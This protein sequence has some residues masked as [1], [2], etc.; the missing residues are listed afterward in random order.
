MNT[1][2]S[3]VNFNKTLKIVCA[4]LTVLIFLPNTNFGQDIL[5]PKGNTTEIK[6]EAVPH[7]F[8]HHKKL[9]ASFSGHMIELIES[10]VPLNKDSPLFSNFGNIYYS[11]LKDGKYSYTIEVKFAT[12]KEMKKFLK[13]VV[14]PNAPAS[15]LVYY[16][17][18]KRKVLK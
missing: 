13:N 14:R 17:T 12:R 18:G 8:N 10:D 15:R 1:Y 2:I 4:I 9:S 6:K 16:K 7:R 11:K 5:T 3:V